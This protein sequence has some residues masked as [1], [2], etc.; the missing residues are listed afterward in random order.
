MKKLL[1]YLLFTPLFS[2][3]QEKSSATIK[4]VVT[5]YFNSYQGDKP[6]L[7]AKIYIVDSSKFKEYDE[8]LSF[9]YDLAKI[10]KTS[11][12]DP[13]FKQIDERLYTVLYRLEQSAETLSATVDAVGNYSISAP[14]GTYYL[15]IQSKGRTGITVTEVKGNIYLTKVRL[16][17]G[18]VR[19][20]SHNFPLQ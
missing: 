10:K 17:K 19:D 18:Q 12:E 15:L 3:A 5:Y 1:F 7:G 13:D 8:D 14:A 20:E 4:G 11:P 9:K 2:L 6:D 16:A